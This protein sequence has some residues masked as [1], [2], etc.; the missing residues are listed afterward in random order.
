M[1]FLKIETDP[2]NL[3][4]MCDKILY[5]DCYRIMNEHAIKLLIDSQL[6]YNRNIEDI[7]DQDR[8]FLEGKSDPSTLNKDISYSPKN[9]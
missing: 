5:Q 2:Y 9:R 8:Q 4:S 1:R 6:N 7:S 3:A